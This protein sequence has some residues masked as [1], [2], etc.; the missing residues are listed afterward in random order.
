MGSGDTRLI[1]EAEA[2]RLDAIVTLVRKDAAHLA[3]E[4][5]IQKIVLARSLISRANQGVRLTGEERKLLPTAQ[6]FLR[7]MAK[8]ILD[9][10]NDRN[11]EIVVA[12]D[13]LEHRLRRVR[14]AVIAIPR[15]QRTMPGTLQRYAKNAHVQYDVV[16]KFA[17]DA[18]VGPV[19][20]AEAIVAK[21]FGLSADR[22][23]HIR[24][25]HG[26][27][28]LKA[29]ELPLVIVRGKKVSKVAREKK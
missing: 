1:E 25:Q 13:E 3:R 14:S 19:G 24:Q 17:L 27:F 9:V 26:E 18:R 10:P 4:V 8:A 29:N 12:C 11:Q 7:A 22:V 28:A 20:V 16:K 5:V 15:G 21:R 23:R 6:A 2:G